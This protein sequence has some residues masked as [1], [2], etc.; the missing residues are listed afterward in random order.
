MPNRYKEK[1]TEKKNI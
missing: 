1:H